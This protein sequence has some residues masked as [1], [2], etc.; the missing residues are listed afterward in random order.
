MLTNQ[1]KLNNLSGT[2]CLW[3]KV[4]VDIIMWLL[5]MPCCFCSLLNGND[6]YW[7][8]LYVIRNY[9]SLTIFGCKNIE[10]K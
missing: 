5:K 4:F 9:I 6:M 1:M 7:N 3:L 10:A 8:D 2:G